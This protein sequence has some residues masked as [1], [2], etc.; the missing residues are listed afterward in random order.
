MDFDDDNRKTGALD[1]DPTLRL[2]LAQ[3]D[4]RQAWLRTGRP[5]DE[6]AEFTPQLGLDLKGYC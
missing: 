4:H 1:D 5:Q 6:P 3:G 2:H